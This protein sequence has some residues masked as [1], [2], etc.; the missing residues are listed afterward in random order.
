MTALATGT[1]A[2]AAGGASVPGAS[3]LRRGVPNQDA[4]AWWPRERSGPQAGLALSDGHGSPVHAR[5][6]IGAR[7]AVE[8]ARDVLSAEAGERPDPEALGAGIVRLWRERVL[9]DFAGR[10]PPDGWTAGADPLPLYGAT[11]VAAGAT[12]RGLVLLQIGDGDLLLRRRDGAILRPLPDDE[13]LVGEQT[14]SLCLADAER[15]LRAALVP[16]IDGIDLVM[17]STDGLSKSFAQ[18]ADFLRLAAAWHETLA[19]MGLAPVVAALPEWLSAASRRG[20]GDDVTLG[21]LM[22]AGLPAAVPSR[23]APPGRGLAQSLL[24]L[25]RRIG[26]PVA[27]SLRSPSGGP[28]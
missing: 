25:L 12:P 24:A 7:L 21:F 19:G 2:W 13:G 26:R 14:Y 3:H 28:S 6:E 1:P 11:L 20:S 8:A 10:A 16:D 15:R 18:E 27:A 17:L 22:P 23:P 5:S 4:V 9:A